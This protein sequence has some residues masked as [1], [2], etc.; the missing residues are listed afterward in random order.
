MRSAYNLQRYIP[1]LFLISDERKQQTF[2]LAPPPHT[3]IKV[4]TKII[5]SFIKGKA[6][7]VLETIHNSR[8]ID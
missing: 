4:H 5:T 8:C 2:A 7:F 6:G 3:T 1:T